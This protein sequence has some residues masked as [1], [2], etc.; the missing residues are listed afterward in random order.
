MKR[1]LCLIESIGS[2]GA[3]RQLTGLAV[4]LKQHGFEVEVC[5]YVKEEF[6]LPYLQANN[7]KALFLAEARDPKRRFGVLRNYIKEYKPDTVISYTASSSMITCLLKALGARFRLLVSERSATLTIDSRERFKFFMYR[8]SD[9]VV[10]NS[11]SQG[12]FI[13]NNFPK[14]SAKVKVITNFVDMEKFAPKT[15]IADS[16]ETL[17]MICVGRL[18]PAKNIPHFIAAISNVVN[19]GYRIHVDWYGKDLGDDYSKECFDVH[20]SYHLENVFEFHA[21]LEDIQEEYH[22]A[23]V[24]CLPSVFEGFPNVLC[25]AMS[26]GLPVLCSNV[27]D[28]PSIAQ[29]GSNGFVFDPKSVDDMTNKIVQFIQLDDGKRKVMGQRSREI[30]LSMFSSETFLQKYLEII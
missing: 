30:A 2:G 5:Y 1:V 12:R 24:F 4:L 15:N 7:V 20:R 22:K 9:F 21:P 17:K 29:D 16:S 26:C 23:N 11:F 27:R 28:N 19:A 18:V 8:W 25:E 3:E 14:L 6:Y 13:D 10:P